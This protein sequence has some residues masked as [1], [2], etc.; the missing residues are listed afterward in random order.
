MPCFA[1]KMLLTRLR[2]LPNKSGVTLSRCRAFSA[3]HAQP[4]R[5]IMEIRNSLRDGERT[6]FIQPDGKPLTWYSCGPTVYDSAHLGHARTYI[7]TDVLRRILVDY[8]SVDM[9]YAMGITDIDDKIIQRAK[10]SGKNWR[11]L[12]AHFEA[13]FKED[14]RSLNVLPPDAY[15]PVTDHIPGIIDYIQGVIDSGYAYVADD[16][17]YFSVNKLG[18]RYACL[19]HTQG[20]TVGL[21]VEESSS[22]AQ[23]GK[24][25]VKDFAL[26]KV[27]VD[28]STNHPSL[29]H[30]GPA[31]SWDSPWGEGRPGWHIEC[32]AMTHACFGSS[33]DVHSGGIDLLFPHHTNEVA[34]W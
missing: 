10:D 29:S 6:L 16:G 2:L 32:S 31:P 18:D 19:G 13:E 12:A 15:L 30:V 20:G 22:V 26:W 3:V 8:H 27:N 11:D 9:Y 7:C 21:D 25:N 4:P 17:V 28:D 14:M 23:T 24:R 1:F 33:L 5:E 34:Q